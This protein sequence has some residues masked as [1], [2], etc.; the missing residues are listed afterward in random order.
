MGLRC[1]RSAAA[2][3]GRVIQNLAEAVHR[4]DA[5]HLQGHERITAF[6]K[7]GPIDT[8]IVSQ[9][10][11]SERTS[12]SGCER[13][14]CSIA[15]RNPASSRAVARKRTVFTC[16]AASMF[17]AFILLTGLWSCNGMHITMSC[18]SCHSW[19]IMVTSHQSQPLKNASKK[20]RD[21]QQRQPEPVR[22]H[23]VCEDQRARRVALSCRLRLDRHHVLQQ[24]LWFLVL[25]ADLHYLPRRS[26]GG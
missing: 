20:L 25:R 22:A 21:S 2:G 1:N 11:W 17:H 26:C 3:L 8:A 12:R 4:E 24:L 16:H 9:Y 5:C 18:T 14:P 6:T 15:T 7:L 10:V 19:Q 23:P 13:S